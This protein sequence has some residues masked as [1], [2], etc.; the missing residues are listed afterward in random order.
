MDGPVGDLIGRTDI[1]YFRPAHVHFL[2]TADGHEPLI[3]HLFQAGA[4]YLDSDVVFGTKAELV[5]EFT[6]REPGP[7][8]DGAEL[9]GAV[10]GGPLRLRPATRRLT[11]FPSLGIYLPADARYTWTLAVRCPMLLP[12]EKEFR[13]VEEE[14]GQQ[15]TRQAGQ[16]EH[17]ST[18]LH[19]P[20]P[21]GVDPGL[22][23]QDLAPTKKEGRTWSAYNIFAL[24]ANDVNSLGNYSFAIGLFALGLGTWQILAALGFGAAFL[25]VLLTLSGYMGIKTGVPFPVMSRISFGTRGAQIPALIRG[26]VAIVWFGIQTYLASLVCNVLLIALF[27]S[28]EPL[29]QQDF[30]GL[31]VLGWISFSVLWVDPGGDRLL[32]DGEH[33]QVRG[34]RRPGDPGDLRRVGRV[35]AVQRRW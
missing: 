26:G 11:R 4:Q 20:V 9:R 2:L 28:L 6:E 22:Y 18:G 35:G 1:S 30:L 14:D 15:V 5:V 19:E 16:P 32:R 7:T 23:N 3:T 12:T 33:P 31:S 27:P 8:P 21:A 13:R 24:W 25:F 34:L 29:S 17:H 10:A